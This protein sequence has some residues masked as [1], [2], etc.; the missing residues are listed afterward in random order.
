MNPRVCEKLDASVHEGK[1]GLSDG[2]ETKAPAG[3]DERESE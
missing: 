3:R 1:R 2:E